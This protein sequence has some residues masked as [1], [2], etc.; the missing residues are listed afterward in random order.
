L[1][2]YSV[3]PDT[4]N[5]VFVRGDELSILLDFDQDLTGYTFETQILRV[6]NI[7]QGEI[8]QTESFL[9]FTQNPVDLSS[10]QINLSLTEIQSGF[11][12]PGS[13]YRWFMRWV[14]PGFVTR[15]VLSGT[16]TA[17]SP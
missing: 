9:S 17:V 15:T 1:S 13:P 4:L 2:T 12:A 10:G 14:A 3:L 6:V 16:I 7:S 11:L 5:I 8:T